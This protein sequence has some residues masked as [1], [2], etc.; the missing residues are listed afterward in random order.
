M[1]D[2]FVAVSRERVDKVSP[3]EKLD[4]IVSLPVGI[5]TKLPGA[6]TR[7]CDWCGTLCWLSPSTRPVL[8]KYQGTPFVCADCAHEKVNRGDAN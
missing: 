6:T 3:P 5:G 2:R 1:K 7:K 8:E 4:M